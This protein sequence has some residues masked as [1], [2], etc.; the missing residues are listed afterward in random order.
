MKYWSWSY[1]FTLL[2]EVQEQVW[3]FGLAVVDL[4]SFASE[5]GCIQEGATESRGYGTRTCKVKGL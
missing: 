4:F 1:K 5:L 3:I 2:R